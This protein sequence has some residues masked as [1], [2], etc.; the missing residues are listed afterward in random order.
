MFLSRV[1]LG[2]QRKKGRPFFGI[3]P[4]WHLHGYKSHLQDILFL[5]QKLHSF[6]SIPARIRAFSRLVLI[7]RKKK[8]KK[9]KKKRLAYR[10]EIYDIKPPGITR[11]V[12]YFVMSS[13]RGIIFGLRVYTYTEPLFRGSSLTAQTPQESIRNALLCFLL[14]LEIRIKGTRKL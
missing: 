8:K 6:A 14:A 13:H 12:D 3:G 1:P 7:L 2:L 9:K 4:L 11:T 5:L 10:R